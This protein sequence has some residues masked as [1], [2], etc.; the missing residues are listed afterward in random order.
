MVLIVRLADLVAH[1][2]NSSSIRVVERNMKWITEVSKLLDIDQEFINSLTFVMVEDVVETASTIGLNLGD[3]IDLMKRAN[4]E[5]C[6]AFMMIE[7]L[8]KERQELTQKMLAEERLEGMLRSKNIAIAT[9]SHYLNNVATAISG[10]VQLMQLGVANNDITDKA[11]SLGSSL[12][13]IDNSIAKILAVLD[14]LKSLSR[15]DD[16][17]FYNDSDALNIDERIKE[18]MEALDESQVAVS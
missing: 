7:E 6:K 11:N 1:N 15:F 17:T 2:I 14:E 3:E 5:L 13:V 16:Q 18:R 4:Q 10:R 9:L 12:K 8:F